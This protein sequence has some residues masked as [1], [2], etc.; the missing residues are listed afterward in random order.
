MKLNK[1]YQDGGNKPQP[2]KPD[3]VRKILRGVIGSG[4]GAIPLSEYTDEEREAYRQ[5]SN[6]NYPWIDFDIYEFVQ[7]LREKQPPP[8][9]SAPIPISLRRM[10]PLPPAQNQI[11]ATDQR[12]LAEMLFDERRKGRE[13]VRVMK[14]DQTMD[15]GHTPDYDVTWDDN[16]K[17]W[18]R[19]DIPQEEKDRYQKEHRVFR[20]PRISF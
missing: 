17:Q 5:Y 13:A 14:A 9:E 15:T 20:T 6:E 11:T 16:R 19:R 18:V 12:Q 3:T 1:T 7:Q 4:D 2:A 8:S 10:F